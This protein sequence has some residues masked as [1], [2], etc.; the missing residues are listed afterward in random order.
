MAWHQQYEIPYQKTPYTFH[1][2]GLCDLQLGNGSTSLSVI[3]TRIKE[4]CDDSVDSGVIIPGDIEDEDRPSTREIR[5]ATFAGR[6]EVIRRDAENHRDWVD[7]HVIPI[8][9]P[10]QKKTK[11]GIMGIIAGHHWRYLTPVQ[12]SA[13]YICQELTRLSGKPVPYL[14]QMMAYLDLRFVSQGKSCRKLGLIMHGEGGGQTK[15]STIA[16]LERAA[17]GFEGDFFIRGHD[18]QLLATKTDK[19]YPK[20]SKRGSD[21][22]MRSRTIAMLNL[23]AATRGYEMNR[24][25]SSYI[26]QG[27]LRPCTLGWGTIKFSLR[28]AY[29]WEDRSSSIKCNMRVEI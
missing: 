26:E 28:R 15:A 9:L 14:G 11:Y 17:Q 18:C 6:G 7:R 3:K 24:N 8:L 23:G 19:L 13:E 16:K 20:E 27:M 25:A 21:P 29:E 12:N 5:A 10:L 1:L 2:H 4:I 22:E